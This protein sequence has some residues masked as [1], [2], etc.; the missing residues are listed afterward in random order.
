[1]VGV[2]LYDVSAIGG[3]ATGNALAN[4]L[5]KLPATIPVLNIASTPS[6][7]N[8]QGSA[9]GVFT[10]KRPGQFNGVQL[11]GGAHSD[12]F[13]S[14]VLFGIPQFLTSLL[15]GFSAPKNVEAV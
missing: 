13:Q 12:A 2:I 7:V 5:D 6:T 4:A 9:N 8:S 15:F 3:S 14:D 1:M 11:V 10:E